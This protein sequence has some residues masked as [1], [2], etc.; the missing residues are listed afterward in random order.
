MSL[1]R[2]EALEHR[3]RALFGEVVLRGTVGS[4]LITV[5]LITVMALL[6]SGL[7]FLKVETPDGPL[8]LIDWLLSRDRK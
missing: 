8:R 5:L 4:W 6:I 3:S 1:F 2:K 7:F